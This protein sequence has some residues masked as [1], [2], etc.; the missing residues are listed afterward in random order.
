M[1]LLDHE[2]D[3]HKFDTQEINQVINKPK[4]RAAILINS[5]GMQA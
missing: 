4:A 2:L 5:N 1:K 3:S